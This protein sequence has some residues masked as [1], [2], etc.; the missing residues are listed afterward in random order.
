[1]QSCKWDMCPY[2][3][4]FG[5]FIHHMPLTNFLAW[6]PTWANLILPWQGK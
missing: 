6:L 2:L 3:G 5:V 1:M 4:S